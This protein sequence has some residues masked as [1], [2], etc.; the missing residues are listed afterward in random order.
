VFSRSGSPFR[1][2][3]V[4]HV[5][6]A[7]SQ[8]ALVGASG[9]GK[10]TLL[11]L[12]AGRHSPERGTIRLG[13][14]RLNDVKPKRRPL[15]YVT[16]DNGPPLRWSVRHAL[17]AALRTGSLDR[18]D[19][20][21]EFESALDYWALRDLVDRRLGSL[22]PGER[23]RCRMAE[24]ELLRPAIFLADRLCASLSPSETQELLDR[25]SRVLRVIGTTSIVEVSRF[26][27]TRFSTSLVALH[28]GRLEQSGTPRSVVESP[29]SIAAALA[30]GPANLFPVDIHENEVHSVLGD[31]SLESPPFQGNGTLLT[32]P[33]HFHPVLPGEESDLIFGVEEA[34]YA[35]GS[36][37]ASGI[38]TGNMMLEV[39]LP[40]ETEVHKGRLMG[41][42][43]DP[44]HFTLVP[45]VVRERGQRVP[46]DALPTVPESR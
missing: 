18:A 13:N 22:S 19:R 27:E 32:R 25:L 14:R 36:W 45:E 11:D 26:E 29:V 34:A 5:F 20:L 30:T 15:L 12:I 17:V 38:L 3:G 41:L 42:R 44:S 39:H 33:W 40:S 9:S 2:D 6:E 8:T 1:I 35:N 31:W 24:I 46:I 37:W 7:R 43:Y 4:S 10:T 21:E 28:E 23:V 16:S